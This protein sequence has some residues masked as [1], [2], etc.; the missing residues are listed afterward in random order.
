MHVFMA[1]PGSKVQQAEAKGTASLALKVLA[2]RFLE[3]HPS[4]ADQVAA[5][6]FSLLL[7]SPKV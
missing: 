6:L 7:V 2:T 1:Q 4:F 3:L 5:F